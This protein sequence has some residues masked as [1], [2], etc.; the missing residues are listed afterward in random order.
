MSSEVWKP[1]VGYEGFYEVSSLG[2]V[3]SVKNKETCLKGIILKQNRSKKNKKYM[4]VGLFV[5]DKRRT[6]RV[7]RLVAEAFIPNPENK[8]QVN[9]INGIQDDNRVEN[10]EWCTCK[11]N[12][13]HGIKNG[14]KIYV[15]GKNNPMHGRKNENANRSVKVDKYD[16]EGNYIETYYSITDA[17]KKNNVNPFT[18]INVCRGR[19]KTAGGYRWKYKD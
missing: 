3:R 13:C 8:P 2:R 4:V 6:C 18:I 10:L 15:K 14:L 17:S 12:I 7:H 9:H 19:G 5:K 16:L 11:E 1:V